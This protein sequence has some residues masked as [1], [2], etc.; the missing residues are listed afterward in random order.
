MHDRRYQLGV[1]RLR[2]PE[3]LAL[4]EVDRVIESSLAGTEARTLLDVGTGSGVFAEAFAV[5]GL[6]VAGVDVSPE[7]V[8][9]ARTH[10]PHGKFR[11][12]SAESLP[13]EAGS[14]DVVFLGLVLH[15]ADDASRALAE[16]RRVARQR[17]AVLEWPYRNDEHGP[18][19]AHRLSPEVIEAAARQVGFQEVR[20]EP[21]SHMVLFRLQVA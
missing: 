10:V 15:E 8:A 14:F 9:A 12:A 11:L 21:L 20:V 5:R 19:L 2:S 4:L 6:I 16:A 3:R 17:V 7:M 13:F 1:D 18:P